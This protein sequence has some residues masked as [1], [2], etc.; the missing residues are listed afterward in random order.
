[1]RRR[2]KSWELRVYLGRDAVSGKKRWATRT[3][4]AGKREAQRAL[5]AMVAEADTGT[6]ART[7]ATVG[8]LLERW[9]EQ[10]K[11]DFSPKTVLETR[12]FID[13]NLLPALGQVP[14]GKLKADALDRYYRS[15]RSGDGN[16]GRSLAPATIRRS[17]ASAPGLVP[18][19]AVGLAG[20]QPGRRYLAPSRHDPG[21]QA[22]GA[23]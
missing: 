11:D 6:L 23:C 12:G 3:V 20:H 14:L 18:G 19:S 7:D 9:F 1:M 2:G 13:R 17:T 10:A 4:R 21:H 16:G 15:L 8:D 5:T 22:A